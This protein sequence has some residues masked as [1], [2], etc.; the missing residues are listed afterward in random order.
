MSVQAD[1]PSPCRS[2]C[3]FE[4]WID[5]S[6]PPSEDDICVGCF[7]TK[8]EIRMWRRFTR[9]EKL[10]VIERLENEKNKT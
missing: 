4:S 10:K 8:H 6:V 5:K 2:I 3:K 9:E 1:P 7:R